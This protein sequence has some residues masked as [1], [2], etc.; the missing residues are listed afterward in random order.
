MD[1]TQILGILEKLGSNISL[2]ES[3]AGFSLGTRDR[4]QKRNT[5]YLLNN[6]VANGNDMIQN[7]RTVIK[8]LRYT[9][10][11]VLNFLNGHETEIKIGRLILRNINR[12]NTIYLKD[13]IREMEEISP[14][15][16]T[17]LEITIDNIQNVARYL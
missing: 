1:H 4:N 8:I 17:F 13:R 10:H 6:F 5:E 11:Y 14:E 12:I 7:S 16:K 15:N 3:N 2:L 9:F